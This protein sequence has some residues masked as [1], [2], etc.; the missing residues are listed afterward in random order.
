MLRGWDVGADLDAYAAICADPE[1]MRFIGD[2][3][4]LTRAESAE[5][6]R[7]FEATWQER[8]FGLYAR[9]A[10]GAPAS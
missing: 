2:G 4:T 8:G 5:R 7:T 10:R 9:R 6:L 1:V 3:S